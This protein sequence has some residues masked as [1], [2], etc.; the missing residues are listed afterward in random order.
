MKVKII[1][2]SDAIIFEQEINAFIADKKV[3]EIKYHSLLAGN[4][5]NDRALILY[6]E[7]DN[8]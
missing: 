1:S 2:Y 8:F 5:I 6:E 7:L 4:R 3:I